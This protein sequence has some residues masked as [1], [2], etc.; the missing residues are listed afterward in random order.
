MTETCFLG[1][2]ML[3][4]KHSLD[5]IYLNKILALNFS[6]ILIVADTQVTNLHVAAVSGVIVREVTS[7][8]E[9][10]FVLTHADGV[11]VPEQVSDPNFNITLVL[12]SGNITGNQDH[13]IYSTYISICERNSME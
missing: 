8:I 9:V 1:D 4:L 2:R 10:S 12:A 11:G 13:S 7:E 5:V 3:T 6:F